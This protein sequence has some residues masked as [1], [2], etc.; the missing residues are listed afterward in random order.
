MAEKDGEEMHS[1]IQAV[2]VFHGDQKVR[3]HSNLSNFFSKSILIP[4]HFLRVQ[5]FFSS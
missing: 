5:D 3:T 2:K 1:L 4:N